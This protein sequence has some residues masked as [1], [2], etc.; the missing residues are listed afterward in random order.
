MSEPIV[1]SKLNVVAGSIQLQD[2]TLY[3]HRCAIVENHHVVPKS[4]WVAAG[5][6][7]TSPMKVLCPNCHYNT[8][9]A[10]DA[11]LRG[12]DVSALPPRCV[13]LARTAMLLAIQNGL[14][15]APTL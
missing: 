2:C 4:W 14:T 11:L 6:P 7:I 13:N 1:I 5:L 12:L 3:A 10:I 9:A 15:P 8:H